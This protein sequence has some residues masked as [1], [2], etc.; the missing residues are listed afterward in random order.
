M[1]L[2]KPLEIEINTKTDPDLVYFLENITNLS[3]TEAYDFALKLEERNYLKEAK[4][5]HKMIITS[6][7]DFIV[8]K[9]DLAEILIKSKEYD[10]A[11]AIFI[12]LLEDKNVIEKSE[13][14]HNL[15]LIY[16]YQNK[17]E[18][19]VKLWK[20]IISQNQEMLKSY[21]A[22]IY[23]AKQNGDKQQVKSLTRR[24]K[25][26]HEKGVKQAEEWLNMNISDISEN[27]IRNWFD[28]IVN[29]ILNLW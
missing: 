2:K 21:D 19:A 22:L 16:W 6:S 3:L 27:P 18:K 11:E 9:I 25:I 20:Q 24:R 7:P 1:K 5:I 23:N 10:E 17:K 8:S 13:I 28:K 4:E 15:G 26:S 29:K 12:E 14:R